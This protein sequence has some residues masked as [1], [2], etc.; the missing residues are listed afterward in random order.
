MKLTPVL[1][2]NLSGGK[3]VKPFVLKD[4]DLAEFIDC[5]KEDFGYML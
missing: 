3:E 2:I 5:I 4:R 1:M